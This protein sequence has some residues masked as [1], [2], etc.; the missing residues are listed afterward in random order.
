MVCGLLVLS[1]HNGR[2]AVGRTVQK[3]NA[4]IIYS[5]GWIGVSLGSDKTKTIPDTFT[6]NS[7]PVFYNRTIG[8]D[9]CKKPANKLWRALKTDAEFFCGLL[10]PSTFLVTVRFEALS[11]F[12]FRHLQTSFL[13][14]ISHGKSWF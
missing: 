9:Y 12:V 4:E 7:F 5:N 1:V 13:L 11:A 10:L 6:S 2:L 8:P 3:S 14:K